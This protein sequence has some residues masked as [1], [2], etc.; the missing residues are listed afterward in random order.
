M[1]KYIQE[2]QRSRTVF[3]DGSVESHRFKSYS[4]SHATIAQLA[5]HL[6]CKKIATGSIPVGGSGE[7]CKILGKHI[8]ALSGGLQSWIKSLPLRGYQNGIEYLF[9]DGCIHYRK[10]NGIDKAAMIA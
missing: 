10:M 9:R 5:E 2:L 7:K 4:G 3:A 6:L 8:P 1:P